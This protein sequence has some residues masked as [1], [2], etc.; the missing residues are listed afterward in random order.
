MESKT[1]TYAEFHWWVDDNDLTM[2]RA[3]LTDGTQTR[4]PET[5]IKREILNGVIEGFKSLYPD[6]LVCEHRNF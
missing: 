1:K 2:V 3:Y 6:L 5:R 4:Y